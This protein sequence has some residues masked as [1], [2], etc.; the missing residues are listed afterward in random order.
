MTGNERTMTWPRSIVVGVDFTACSATALAQALRIAEGSRAELHVV[1]VIETLV[2]MDLEEALTPFQADIRAGLV[3]DA[4]RSWHE[5]SAKVPGASALDLDVSVDNPVA[6]LLHR[7][8]DRSADLLVLGTHGT[9]PPGRGA[10]TLATAC[11]RKAPASVL[12]VGVPH[13]GRFTSIVACVD[14][15]ATSLRALAHA[16]RVAAHEGARLH[17]LHVF[18][19]PWHRLH[20]RAPTPQAALDYQKQYRDG[21]QRRLEAFCEPLRGEMA[22][23]DTQYTVFDHSGHG[24][25]ITEFV[26][27]VGGDLVVLGTRGRTNLRDLLL[28][29]TAERVVRDTACSILAV[30]PEGFE[31]RLPDEDASPRRRIETKKIGDVMARQPITVSPDMPVGRLK[32]LFE[33]HDFNLFPVVDARGLLVGLVT[34]LDFLKMFAPDRRRLIP[35]LRVLWAER[36]EEIMSRGVIAVDADDTVAAAADLMV[37][38]RLRTLPVVQSRGSERRLV[39]IVSRKDLLPSLMLGS[40]DVA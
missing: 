15:S 8:R 34:K 22:G 38:S 19:A 27:Q 25:G 4:Q 3:E 21:L 39:G 9:S 32:E 6:A 36:V 33:A 5:F 17:V 12:L 2:A 7:L 26:E 16:V 14:F 23:L 30:K 40:E 35:D 37:Q 29:S 1:H 10:G 31:S 24:R 13:A 28:G 18:H 20:Y 11:V